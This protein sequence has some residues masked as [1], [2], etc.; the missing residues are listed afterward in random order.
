MRL[1]DADALRGEVYTSGPFTGL[2]EED[3]I[4]AAPTVCCEEC[5]QWGLGTDGDYRGGASGVEWDQCAFHDRLL[6]NDDHCKHFERR[7]P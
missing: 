6:T 7:Q 3:R 2:V 5:G 1:I 4:D